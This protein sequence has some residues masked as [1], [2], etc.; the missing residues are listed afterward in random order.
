MFYD[1]I[2]KV[3]N[4]RRICKTTHFRKTPIPFLSTT[5]DFL[6]ESSPKLFLRGKRLKFCEIVFEQKKY[7]KNKKSNTYLQS[8]G[9]TLIPFLTSIFDSLYKNFFQNIFFMAN[10]DFFVT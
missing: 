7:V 2:K 10:N 3:K 5:F 4:K 8:L 6:F 9:K 1:A